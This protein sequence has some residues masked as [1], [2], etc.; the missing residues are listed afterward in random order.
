[1]LDIWKLINNSKE[2]ASFATIKEDGYIVLHK[3]GA[4]IVIGISS[5]YIERLRK[6]SNFLQS[7]EKCDADARRD[8]GHKIW[9]ILNNA[10]LNE[11][12]M[13]VS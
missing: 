3:D 9:L 6:I 5:E 4:R 10:K 1:M 11:I 8:L 7:M 13:E 2:Y 12:K